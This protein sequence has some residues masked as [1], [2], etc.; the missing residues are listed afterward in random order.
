MN[1]RDVLSVTNFGHRIAEDEGEELLSYFVE[2]DQWKR[3]FSGDVDVVYG[4]KGSGKSAIYSLMLSHQDRLKER[5]VNVVPAENPRGT[6]VF[7]NLV[8]DPPTSEDEFRG[9]WKLYFLCLIA[10]YL[11]KSG[12]SLDTAAAVVRSV[13]EAGLLPKDS[14]LRGMLRS[15]LDYVRNLLKAEAIEGGIKLDPATGMPAGITGRITLRE[16]GTIQRDKGIIS[17]DSLLKLANAA[18]GNSGQKIWLLL[19]RLDVAFAESSELESNSLRAVFRVYLDLLAFEH[20][21]LKIFL[22]T[23]I[24]RRITSQGFREAS[25]I[26]RHITLSWDT[27][28]LLNLV[29]R[30]ALHNEAV[31]SM[32]SVDPRVVLSAANQQEKLFYRLF[33]SQVDAGSRK[34]TTLDWMLSRTCDGSK[35]TAP[36]ELIHLLSCTR[37]VQLRKLEL[38]EPE[39]PDEALIDRTSLKEALP[40]VS[41][42]RYEQTL[43]AEFPEFR[44]PLQKLKGEKT[45]QT[46]KTLAKIWGTERN[47][48]LSLAEK[49]TGIGFFEKRGPAHEP[50]FWV[51]FLYRDA[52]EMVQ[53]PAE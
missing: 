13:E 21:A 5:G 17:A 39:P 4:A 25:H 6:P 23:D 27:A 43:C 32:Y 30:R 8:A 48:A 15:A 51:P 41:K 20:I 11:R 24:W 2:T 29:I 38:G 10:D 44:K 37:N 26:T 7:T 34:P 9:L 50:L 42:V 47:A 49:L 52:L 16:P 31:R 46:P 36:R 3:I 35:Q 19:D 33:P 12:I 45:Q 28:S 40:E 22:R 1:K 53:G 18:L 14:S